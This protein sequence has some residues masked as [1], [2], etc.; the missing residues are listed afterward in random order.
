MTNLYCKGTLL[1]EKGVFYS[2]FWI[3][4]EN[5][6]SFIFTG[7][8]IVGMF[9]SLINEDKIEYKKEWWKEK[10]WKNIIFL[11]SFFWHIP[12]SVFLIFLFSHFHFVS[13]GAFEFEKNSWF[14]GLTKIKKFSLTSEIDFFIKLIANFLLLTFATV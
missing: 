4:I 13:W 14:D 7:E 1:I 9:Y 12:F 6:G 8:K 3:R 5:G 11:F 10:Y 2:L